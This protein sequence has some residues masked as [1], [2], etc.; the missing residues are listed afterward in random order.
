MSQSS[1]GMFRS[2]GARSLVAV[3]ADVGVPSPPS[4]GTAANA[5]A[6]FGLCAYR[7]SW[8]RAGQVSPVELIAWRKSEI[9][10][11]SK[12]GVDAVLWP[13]LG[14][15]LADEFDWDPSAL[16]GGPGKPP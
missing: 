9:K 8:C 3:S 10:P 16:L 4:R 14:C 5:N 12:L 1:Q 11:R 6:G 2:K 7:G 13:R 15:A